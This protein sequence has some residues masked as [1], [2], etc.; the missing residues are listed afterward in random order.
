MSSIYEKKRTW[1]FVTDRAKLMRLLSE[2]LAGKPFYLK[3]SD[4]PLQFNPAGFEPESV[5]LAIPSGH[6]PDD[7]FTLYLT[8]QRHLEIDFQ[9]LDQPESDLIRVE[10]L[11]ARIGV[12]DRHA[13]RIFVKEEGPYATNFRIYRRTIQSDPGRSSVINTIIF[14]EVERAL[15]VLYPGFRIYG[16]DEK[17]RPLETKLLG[18]SGLI[19]LVE[20]TTR[21]ESYGSTGP[22]VLN[23]REELDKKDLFLST[24]QRYR[25]GGI[26]SVV[27]LPIQ[28]LPAH[29]K[30]RTLAYIH[31]ESRQGR[32]DLT[33]LEYF[34]KISS[35]IIK[36]IIEAN[37]LTLSIKQKVLNFSRTGAALEI[38]NE[39]LKGHLAQKN[40]LTF[41]LVFK[42]QAPIRLRA[43]IRHMEEKDAHMVVGVEFTG[44]GE[45]AQSVDPRDT[46]NTLIQQL[47]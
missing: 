42:K 29:E 32:V 11:R 7:Q 28:F 33:T 26:K 21:M 23:F 37:A 10:P 19:I 24:F 35:S 3:D 40:V 12:I 31:Y 25:A 8:L 9:L 43:V 41:D 22:G 44:G 34:Q 30:P 38:D 36:R 4:P 1:K 15:G 46:L 20:D 18:E 6:R 2:K 17:Q 39:E 14:K 27:T 16:A 5:L 45:G 47:K 13:P